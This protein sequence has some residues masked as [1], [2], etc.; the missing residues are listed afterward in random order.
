MT[1]IGFFMFAIAVLMIVLD[2]ASAVKGPVWYAVIGLV[3]FVGGAIAM[4]AGASIALWRV[5][6]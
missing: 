3:L 6:P 4:A 5:M 1:A 2:A